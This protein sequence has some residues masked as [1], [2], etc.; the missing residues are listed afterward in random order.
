M[1]TTCPALYHLWL[2]YE[3]VARPALINQIFWEVRPKFTAPWCF[4]ICTATKQRLSVGGN[5]VYYINNTQFG[6]HHF[7][8]FWDKLLKNNYSQLGLPNK[9]EF[10]HNWVRIITPDFSIELILMRFG[11]FFPL[12]GAAR[13]SGRWSRPLFLSHYTV[14]YSNCRTA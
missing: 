10:R 2:V 3:T 13:T 6:A 5:R 12:N 14:N 4:C 9:L 11:F 7:F 8:F 1:L